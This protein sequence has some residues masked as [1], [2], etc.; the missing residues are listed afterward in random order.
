VQGGTT[1]TDLNKQLQG[2]DGV[3]RAG[4]LADFGDLVVFLRWQARDA[5]GPHSVFDMVST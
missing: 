3:A 2:R 1:H 5:G 4:T